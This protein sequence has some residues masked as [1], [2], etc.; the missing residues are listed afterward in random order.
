MKII[1][2]IVFAITATADIPDTNAKIL[3]FVNTVVGKQVG[4]GECWDL[5]AA[6][7]DY[8][9]AYLDRTNQ[10]NI[11]IFG[12]EYNPKKDK[13]YPGD[14][15][16]IENLKIEYTKE[17]MI[18]TESMTHHTAIIYEVVDTDLYKIAHQNNNFSGRKV[19]ISELRMNDIKKGTVTFYR[20]H[21]K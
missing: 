17:N 20:P 1:P 3:E 19:G 15:I 6:A 5:A 16:Q 8:S 14:I 13:V 21:K 4:R 12:K 10:K 11:Y 18:I 2:L 9:G 7:L